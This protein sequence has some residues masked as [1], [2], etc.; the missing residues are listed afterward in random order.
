M[1]AFVSERR[2]KSRWKSVIKRVS[3]NDYCVLDYKALRE[4]IIE[5]ELVT[6]VS[7]QSETVAA[8]LADDCDSKRTERR[9]VTA[10]QSWSHCRSSDSCSG[11][12]FDLVVSDS[13]FGFLRKATSS[14]RFRR[15]NSVLQFI[16]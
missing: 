8:R 6:L 15:P 13:T 7:E 12:M 5:S 3:N 10:F 14:R 4:R 1:L 2:G 11:E 9:D 16:S